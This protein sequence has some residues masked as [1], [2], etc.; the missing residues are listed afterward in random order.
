MAAA[1]V[2][3]GS[4]IIYMIAILPP[5]VNQ[6]YYAG[7]ILVLIWGYTFTRNNFV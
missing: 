4:G 5:P 7:L 1:M 2:V 3:S 6:T